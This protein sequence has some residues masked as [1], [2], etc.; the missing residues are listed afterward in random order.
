MVKTRK[1]VVKLQWKWKHNNG[2]GNGKNNNNKFNH[3]NI[4]E[5]VNKNW[6]S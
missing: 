6:L 4:E 1:I 5:N 2:N 3:D